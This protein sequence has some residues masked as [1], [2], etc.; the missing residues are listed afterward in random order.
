MQN[1]SFWLSLFWLPNISCF[2]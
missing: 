1:K 2:G